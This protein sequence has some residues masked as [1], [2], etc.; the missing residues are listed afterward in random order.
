MTDLPVEYES[1]ARSAQGLVGSGGDDVR[2]LEG[3]ARHAR[4]H[5]AAD[6]RHVGH[7]VR[8]ALVR[9]LPRKLR[10]RRMHMNILRN[11]RK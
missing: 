2:V 4:R 7:Q 11:R 10:W 9:D 6:V 3:V 5:Q 8:P 1:A